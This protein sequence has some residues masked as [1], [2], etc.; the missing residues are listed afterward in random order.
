MR[1]AKF[2]SGTQT[3]EGAVEMAPAYLATLSPNKQSMFRPL[4]TDAQPTPS[5]TQ[6]VLSAGYVIEPTQVR[7]TWALREKTADEL[8]DES[9]GADRA[10]IAAAL[11]AIN[12]QLA[13]TNAQVDAMTAAQVRSLVRDD[14]RITLQVLRYMVRRVKR[15]M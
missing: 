9:I 14:R 8:E 13:I 10:Q 1:Y 15:G 4:V 11:D 7:E 3:I 5:S 2:I 6:V 12:T